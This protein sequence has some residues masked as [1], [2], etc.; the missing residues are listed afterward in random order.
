MPPPRRRLGCVGA[1]HVPGCGMSVRLPAI[2]RGWQ[3][4][5]RPCLK[6]SHHRRLPVPRHRFERRPTSGRIGPGREPHREPARRPARR[7]RAG[8]QRRRAGSSGRA[9]AYDGVGRWDGVVRQFQ[10]VDLF[11]LW[12]GDPG[13]VEHRRRRV[14]GNDAV[15]TSYQQSRH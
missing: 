11:G 6:P 10:G 14:G 7:A 2:M 8:R 13:Q 9:P 12:R 3:Q 15:T 1:R 5:S 4:T